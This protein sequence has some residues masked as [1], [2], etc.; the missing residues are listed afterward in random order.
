M[1]NLIEKEAASLSSNPNQEHHS[2]ELKG[3]KNESQGMWKLIQKHESYMHII[4]S[5]KKDFYKYQEEAN[6]S[7][8]LKI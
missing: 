6:F 7:K 5:L 3:I 8:L 4:D 2:H 1:A